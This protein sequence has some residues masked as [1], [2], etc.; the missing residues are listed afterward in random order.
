MN[1]ALADERAA[2]IPP[3]AAQT[4]EHERRRLQQ[5]SAVLKCLTIA[6]LYEDWYDEGIDTADVALVVRRL[7]DEAIAALDLVALT[8]SD[9]V[10][11]EA[12]DAGSEV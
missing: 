11:P 12:P 1:G 8:R 5:A 7:V 4:I 9:A 6:V 3:G 10:S 2:A